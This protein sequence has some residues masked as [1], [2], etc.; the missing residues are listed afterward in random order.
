MRKRR[1]KKKGDQ[2]T[3]LSKCKRRT[4]W[5]LSQ[6]LLYFLATV[7]KRNL[8]VTH[9]VQFS[10]VLLLPLLQQL[11]NLVVTLHLSSCEEQRQD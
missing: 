9:L 6:Q 10:D 5:D 2:Y 3:L 4:Y 8:A 7:K 11:C 1:V